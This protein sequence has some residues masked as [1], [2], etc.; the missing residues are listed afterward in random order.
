[1]IRII[2]R[3]G[4]NDRCGHPFRAEPEHSAEA[5]P[6]RTFA[7]EGRIFIDPGIYDES[8]IEQ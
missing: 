5:E 7:A 4:R 3:A 6:T 2:G 1:M 8:T